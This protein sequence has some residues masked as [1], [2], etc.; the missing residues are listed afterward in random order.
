M[1]EC[2]SEHVCVCVCDRPLIDIIDPPAA[3]VL[4]TEER[5]DE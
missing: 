5:E 4:Q 3:V 2:A 1:S